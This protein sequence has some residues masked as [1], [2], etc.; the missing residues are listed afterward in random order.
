MELEKCCIGG[1]PDYTYGDQIYF[2]KK[3]DTPNEH[4]NHLILNQVSVFY[5]TFIKQI[6]SYMLY[7]NQ[8]INLNWNLHII[9]GHHILIKFSLKL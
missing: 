2:N 6:K 9:Y 3:I 8:K 4:H 1:M 5:M 7:F